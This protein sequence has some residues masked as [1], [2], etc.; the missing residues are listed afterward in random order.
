MSVFGSLGE[1][2]TSID[3]EPSFWVLKLQKFC[4]LNILKC[5]RC[6]II[7]VVLNESVS[8]LR[9]K[10][11]FNETIVGSKDVIK[12]FLLYILGKFLDKENVVD[13]WLSANAGP[14]SKRRVS[15][16]TNSCCIPAQLV[17]LVL[18]SESDH[19]VDKF[20][21]HLEFSEFFSLLLGGLAF[22]KHTR[23]ERALKFGNEIRVFLGIA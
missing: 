12:L 14:R 2:D 20:A 9:D 18:E 23:V 4:H 15:A 16:S 5:I 6:E 8:F 3:F 17:L 21:F 19:L 1:I 11:N 10:T 13:F 22:L 7:R